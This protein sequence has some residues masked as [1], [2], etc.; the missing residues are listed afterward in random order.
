MAQPINTVDGRPN[1]KL[2]IFTAFADTALYLYESIADWARTEL[3]LPGAL[4]TGSGS[5]KTNLPGLRT[6]LSSVLT[7]FAPKAKERPAEFAD[8]GEL[9]LLIA[10]DCISEGQNLQD[11]DYLVNYDIHWNPVRIIQRFGRIDRI[12]SPN[13][14]IQLVNL[15]PNMA[16]DEY[17]GLEQRVSGR[18]VLLDISAIGEENLI[19]RDAGNVMQDLE[20]R[21]KQLQKLREAVID[22]E[23]LSSGI[24]I[25]DLTLADYRIELAGYLREH[26]GKLAAMPLGAYAVTSSADAASD[27]S[28]A[29]QP[30]A[31][32][33]LRAVGDAALATIEPG[34]PLAPH[35][36]VHV[37]A[38]G[39]FQLPHS[40]AKQV[41]DRLKG[42]CLGRDLVDAQACA[43]FDKATKAGRQMLPYQAMLQQAIASVVGKS[44][45]RAV[46]SLF[47]P[48]GTHAKKGEFAGMGDFEVVAFLVIV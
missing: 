21:R 38:D 29:L 28:A 30:G 36:V 43:R 12:G 1:R 11:G 41:L 37:S 35:C 23:D 7:A 3:G 32:F 4:V 14:V 2:I 27:E 19:E 26:P 10:T 16:L 45:E 25:A 15:W 18:M 46:A 47:T 33:C 8:E 42:L 5:N 44:Q 13:A 6:D 22:L 20:Y 31:I 24:S 34:Y 9:D 17:I 48:G 40:Q 39:A